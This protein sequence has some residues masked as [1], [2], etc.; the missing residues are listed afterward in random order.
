MVGENRLPRTRSNL[1]ENLLKGIYIYDLTIKIPGMNIF[2]KI[3]TITT[4]TV[5]YLISNFSNNAITTRRSARAIGIPV[6]AK[7][8]GQYAV[9]SARSAT[10]AV[11]IPTRLRPE[12]LTYLTKFLSLKEKQT[13]LQ[14]IAR[15]YVMQR[16][17]IAKSVADNIQG[18]L[19][20]MNAYAARRTQEAKAALLQL[21][22]DFH[23]FIQNREFMYNN[24]DKELIFNA[25]I[26]F[27]LTIQVVYAPLSLVLAVLCLDEETKCLPDIL[28]CEK[29]LGTPMIKFFI[30]DRSTLRSS[31]E[32][33]NFINSNEHLLAP[34]VRILIYLL[35]TVLAVRLRSN[36]SRQNANPSI[37]SKYLCFIFCLLRNP[38]EQAQFLFCK[39]FVFRLIKILGSFFLN[40]LYVFYKLNTC[41]IER[42]RLV[43]LLKSQPL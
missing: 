26:Y 40:R 4:H 1:I 28:A 34:L 9:S 5:T 41:D 42:R 15:P 20:E 25:P 6:A 14:S 38:F 27:L 36:L 17:F 19:M 32:P 10:N 11:C 37:L 22:K 16:L 3:K 33:I 12:L 30:S 7:E 29:F 24:A 23:Q 31:L 39:S 43:E 18:H 35:I 8:L 2:N 13:F 21:A